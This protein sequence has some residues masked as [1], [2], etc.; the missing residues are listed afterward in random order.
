VFFRLTFNVTKTEAAKPTDTLSVCIFHRYL[1]AISSL[2]T[3][4]VISFKCFRLI[5]KMAA[6]PRSYLCMLLLLQPTIPTPNIRS[7]PH[8]KRSMNPNLTLWS[9]LPIRRHQPH[10]LNYTHTRINSTKYR[11][12]SIEPRSG[13]ECYKELRSVRIGSAVGHAYDSGSGVF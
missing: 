11:M 3:P 10:P 4:N 1:T 5:H 6:S 9:I 12:L 13:F 7:L 2:L 8:G